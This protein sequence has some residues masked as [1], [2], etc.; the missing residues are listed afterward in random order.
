MQQIETLESFE[1][2][3]E[4]ELR[5]Y[6]SV[7]WR[8]KVLILSSLLIAVALGVSYL[9][10]KIPVYRSTVSVHITPD[11]PEVVPQ[12]NDN[13]NTV[14]LNTFYKTQYEI[15][16]SRAVAERVVNGLSVAERK[17]LIKPDGL[18]ASLGKKPDLSHLSAD[19]IRRMAVHQVSSNMT[20]YAPQDTQIVNVSF[21]AINPNLAAHVANLIAQS[22]IGLERERRE[23][24]AQ[25]NSQWLQKQLVSLRKNL[26]QSQAALQ[27]FKQKNG[28]L[29]SKDME[30]LNDKQLSTVSQ[31]LLDAHSKRIQAQTLYEQAKKV[32]RRHRGYNTLASVS[33]DPI[34]QKLRLKQID[35][36]QQLRSLEQYYGSKAQKVQETRAELETTTSRLHSETENV[37][38]SLRKQYHAALQ[39]E[40]QLKNEQN[41]VQAGMRDLGSKRF[42]LEKLERNVAMNR[43]LYETFK[44]RIKDTSLQ[45][46]SNVTVASVLDRAQVPESP[47]SPSRNRV[48]GAAL[49]VSLFLGIALAF[50]RENMSRTF[51][52]PRQ[53]E[54]RLGLP[55]LGVL[56]EV[57]RRHRKRLL[58]PTGE[59]APLPIADALGEIRSRLEA[60]NLQHPPQVVMVTSALPGEGKSTLSSN[61]AQA[62]S[63]RGRTLLLDA[64]LRRAGLR[65]LGMGRGFADFVQ[66]HASMN[67]CCARIEE[68]PNLFVM[69][70]G[71]HQVA[72]LAFLSSPAVGRS[73]QQLR[74]HFETIVIDTP[75]ICAVS[76]AFALGR[77]VD[78]VVLTVQARGTPFE[79][80]TDALH[81]LRAANLNVLGVV[82]SKANLKEM[83]RYGSPYVAYG[84]Y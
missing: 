43:D 13:G 68:T 15:V 9:Y 60:S 58:R 34:I 69:G 28:L 42:E 29:D 22:Y 72:P 51:H 56:P 27:R 39:Q 44:N 46:Q 31:Q 19:E 61:L 37:L 73:L 26:D 79:V 48:L 84:N 6:L 24:A 64:D 75:P 63:Q 30:A 17:Q 47:F 53:M 66:G 76:D 57:G 1:F 45:S 52:T 82:L 78:G 50:L 54:T 77:Y 10:I 23:K 62:Y 11:E 67:S 20:V 49:L 55:G 35:L 40:H 21:Y 16:R 80:V 4:P 18:M 8:H 3:R 71:S 41:S 25:S 32:E 59:A 12:L 36:Q 38:Q 5:E 81:R 14:D 2:Q 70:A 7:L 83:A 33:N 74:G 65:D